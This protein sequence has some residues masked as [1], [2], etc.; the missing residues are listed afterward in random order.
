MQ[1]LCACVLLKSDNSG[2]TLRNTSYHTLNRTLTITPT[3]NAPAKYG[4][5]DMLKGSSLYR[6]A[7][8]A[9]IT[10]STPRHTCNRDTAP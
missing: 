5:V 4:G 7:T 9:L 8:I 2:E 10:N 1:F 3:N 6:R